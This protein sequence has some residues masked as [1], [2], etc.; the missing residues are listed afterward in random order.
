[1]TSS[2]S[3]GGL[4]V[5]V[6]LFARYAELVGR[7]RVEI[8]LAGGATVGDLIDEFRR[9]VPESLTLPRRPLCAVNLT[10]VLSGHPLRN[11]DEVAILPPLAGG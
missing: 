11:G 9:Q 4:T 8:S 10:H 3:T 2:A 6:L 7:S 1:M 5:S